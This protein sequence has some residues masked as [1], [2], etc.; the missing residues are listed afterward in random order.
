[1]LTQKYL[2]EQI[3]YDHETG[4]FYW[5]KPRKGRNTN[6]PAG[7]SAKCLHTSY[8]RIRLDGKYYKA[9]RL[10]WLYMYG[11]MPKGVI[12]HID[13]NGENNSISN[14]RDVSQSKNMSNRRLNTNSKSRVKGV[15][16]SG[17][18]WIAYINHG[19]KSKYL[20]CY[21][22]KFNAIC[23][24]KSEENKLMLEPV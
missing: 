23:A 24:R 14:L 11:E 10:A 4:I 3:D 1:M 19:N 12:D 5:K 16:K 8:L 18:S 17:R 13:R 20:G 2:K 9:H 7:C 21:K 6:K 15:C 22:D